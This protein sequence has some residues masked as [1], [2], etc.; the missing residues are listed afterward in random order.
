MVYSVM[1]WHYRCTR[2]FHIA[3]LTRHRVHNWLTIV[4]YLKMG[5]G[6]SLASLAVSGRRKRFFKTWWTV[7]TFFDKVP[8]T[9]PPPSWPPH[10][11]LTSYC[12]LYCRRRDSACDHWCCLKVLLNSL[13]FHSGCRNYCPDAVHFSNVAYC[14][15]F[16][17][18]CCWV[19]LFFLSFFLSSFFFSVVVVCQ[20]FLKS[21]FT[22]LVA[23]QFS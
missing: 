22:Q 2:D 21:T 11:S 4:K 17:R 14:D 3:S 9:H 8:L 19:P 1:V 18:F 6:R 12:S 15:H 5:R 23:T 10:P 16:A 20:I 13:K 7:F